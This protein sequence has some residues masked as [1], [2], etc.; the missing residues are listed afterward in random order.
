MH[1]HSP[2]IA[3]LTRHRAA[4]R[5]RQL[6]DELHMLMGS[7]PDLH[8]AFDAD[9]LPLAFILKRDSGPVQPDTGPRRAFSVRAKNAVK[10]RPASRRTHTRGRRKQMPNE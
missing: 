6:L 4:F 7:F 5:F 3:P 9:E 1:E 8:D 10:R 2:D